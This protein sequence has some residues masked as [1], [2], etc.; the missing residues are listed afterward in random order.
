[1]GW[2]EL[3][4]GINGGGDG[5]SPLKNFSGAG[6]N[7]KDGD[8]KV[9]TN[10]TVDPVT[11]VATYT[12]VLNKSDIGQKGIQVRFTGDHIY[13]AGP[14]DSF[15]TNI[16]DANGLNATDGQK[17]QV[18]KIVAGP[19]IYISAPNGQ[20]V[21]TV[22]AEPLNLK[23]FTHDLWD[24]SWSTV[25][26]N[27]DGSLPFGAI[28]QFTAVGYGGSSLRSRDGGNWVQMDGHTSTSIYG[29]SSEL[30]PDIANGHLEYVGVGP[31][32][33]GFYGLL[34]S[35]SDSMNKIGQL[36]DQFGPIT[37]DF[38]STRVFPNASAII[39][40]TQ[41]DGGI[42]AW[43]LLT[44]STAS[45][46]SI[47]NPRNE[48]LFQYKI[49]QV[50]LQKSTG[51]NAL[52]FS[53]GADDVLRIKTFMHLSD[54]RVVPGSPI[55]DQYPIYYIDPDTLQT[56]YVYYSN[57]KQYFSPYTIVYLDGTPTQSGFLNQ[58]NVPAPGW[59]ATTFY[60]TDIAITLGTAGYGDLTIGHHT[61]TVVYSLDG[62]N[63]DYQF[64]TSFTIG[65]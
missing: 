37:E 65:P 33:V 10:V 32:G 18:D 8:G 49:S 23:P 60:D 54:V 25:V 34:G 3:G 13:A 40:N 27:N 30:N 63:I 57:G 31:D 62:Y 22:A 52:I 38:N 44:G 17:L 5:A 11:K 55:Q 39:P 15:S 21:V 42:T 53:S 24:V 46:V 58:D 1:M 7:I 43:G 61:L 14:L 2:F 47:F 9:I 26:Y 45:G 56:V 51:K 16:A 19:G 29:V 50:L 12:K 35:G 6:F 41:F 4:G 48:A 36:E 59:Q 64:T 20:G 28:G